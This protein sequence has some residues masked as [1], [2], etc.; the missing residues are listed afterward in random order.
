MWL[1]PRQKRAFN[2]NRFHFNFRWFWIMPRVDDGLGSA[3]V[4]YALY[5]MSGTPKSVM[6]IG[7]KFAY[8]NDASE[9]PD[10]YRRSTNMMVIL[11]Y[12]AC[13]WD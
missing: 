2:P 7:G 12:G 1:G 13:H 3:L 11:F 10:T 9:T 8:P 6:A 4:D 5:G